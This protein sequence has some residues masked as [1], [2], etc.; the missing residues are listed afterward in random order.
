MKYMNHL[1]KLALL[2]SLALSFGVYADGTLP[3]PLNMVDPNVDMELDVRSL[4]KRTSPFIDNSGVQVCKTSDELFT[5]SGSVTLGTDKYKVVGV[6]RPKL[7]PLARTIVAQYTGI[8]GFTVLEGRTDDAQSFTTFTGS[9]THISNM[10]QS[11]SPGA[12]AEV[13][14]AS[15][16][17]NLRRR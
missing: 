11:G 15:I 4:Q 6:C 5:A 10:P 1:R 7:D 16:E 13:T 9:M 2:S 12:E 14:A 8:P 17:F 3:L